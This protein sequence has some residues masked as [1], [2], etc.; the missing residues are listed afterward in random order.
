[1][2]IEQLQIIQG[3]TEETTPRLNEFLGSHPNA[4][5][6]SHAVNVQ[7]FA[8]VAALAACIA[9]TTAPT[10]AISDAAKQLA[11]ENNIDITKL[12]GTGANGN[13]TKNDVQIVIDNPPTEEEEKPEAETKEEAPLP[14]IKES[15]Y[16][17]TITYHAFVVAIVHN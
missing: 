9:G 5:I 3:T 14:E 17:D 10:I 11:E 7:H 4:K 12:I 2:N 1:M 15:S 16:R 13:I 8:K 6:L